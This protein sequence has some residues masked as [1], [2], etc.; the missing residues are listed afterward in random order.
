MGGLHHTLYTFSIV[1]SVSR[2][3]G[4]T[5]FPVPTVLVWSA[6]GTQTSVVGSQKIQKRKMCRKV[7]LLA[8]VSTDG[9]A[10]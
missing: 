9:F 4:T 5:L 7:L 2:I 1:D 3:F 6:M 10:R 8:L